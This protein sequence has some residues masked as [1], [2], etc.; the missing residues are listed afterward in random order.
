[1][2]MGL[3]SLAK[4]GGDVKHV[5]DDGS[6]DGDEPSLEVC[7]NVLRV[8]RTFRHSGCSYTNKSLR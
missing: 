1:M 2:K 4:S 7:K 8:W 6:V 3:T 5:G